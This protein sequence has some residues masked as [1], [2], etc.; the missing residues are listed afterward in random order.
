[1]MIESECAVAVRALGPSTAHRVPLSR[2]VSTPPTPVA[3][4]SQTSWSRSDTGVPFASCASP[5]VCSFASC[6]SQRAGDLQLWRAVRLPHMREL[7]AATAHT[8]SCR[9]R[10]TCSARAVADDFNYDRAK[11]DLHLNTGWCLS[12]VFTF[13]FWSQ[14]P[15]AQ[16]QHPHRDEPRDHDASD[17]LEPL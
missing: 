15:A 1:M 5:R 2:S 13:V 7:C 8:P 11:L 10:L 16:A 12:L 4:T 6:T 3:S 17:A 9:W 14:E